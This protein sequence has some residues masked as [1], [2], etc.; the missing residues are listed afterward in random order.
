MEMDY[1]GGIFAPYLLIES[2][3]RNY[4]RAYRLDGDHLDGR[5]L[6]RK[7]LAKWP[8]ATISAGPDV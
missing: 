1:S 5:G 4:A 6:I 2:F 7:D 3:F 8:P